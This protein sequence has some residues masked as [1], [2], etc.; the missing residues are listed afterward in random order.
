MRKGPISPPT[1]KIPFVISIQNSNFFGSAMR[2][3]Q[4][5]VIISMKLYPT[6]AMQSQAPSKKELD[7]KEKRQDA[8]PTITKPKFMML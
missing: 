2:I 5:F 8:T 1:P 3:M 6:E 7:V 4:T